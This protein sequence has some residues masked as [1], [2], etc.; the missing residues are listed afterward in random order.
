MAL[1]GEAFWNVEPLK[2]KKISSI[3]AVESR[4]LSLDKFVKDLENVF[5]DRKRACLSN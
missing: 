5:L 4:K 2:I 3:K 1:N